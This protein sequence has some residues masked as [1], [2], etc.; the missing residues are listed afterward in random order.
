MSAIDFVR[1]QPF[2]IRQDFRISR[3]RTLQLQRDLET[4]KTREFW[5]AAC[6]HYSEALGGTQRV[7]L[8]HAVKRTRLT[9]DGQIECGGYMGSRPRFR[10]RTAFSVAHGLM[11][12]MHG[13]G[14][15]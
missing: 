1:L 14:H 10:A 15:D 2:F 11:V 12:T 5:A 7:G 3:S 8:R 13:L 9:Q 6:A 4:K